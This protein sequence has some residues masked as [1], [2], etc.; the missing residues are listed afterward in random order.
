MGSKNR[1]WFR[2]HGTIERHREQVELAL[3]SLN[4]S[5]QLQVPSEQTAIEQ[6]IGGNAL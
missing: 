6:S 4:G 1:A 5:R 2:D 3:L